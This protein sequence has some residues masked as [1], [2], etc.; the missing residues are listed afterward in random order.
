[1]HHSFTRGSDKMRDFPLQTALAILAFGLLLGAAGMVVP[2]MR[3]PELS[4]FAGIIP[5]PSVPAPPARVTRSETAPAPGSAPKPKEPPVL[6]DDSRGSLDRFYQALLR[7]ERREPGAITRIVHYG[8]SPT[9]ADLI[10]G[11]VRSLLQKQFGNAGHGFILAD[12]PWSWYRHAGM[13]IYAHGWAMLPASRFDADDG[14]FGLGGVTFSGSPPARTA[15]VFERGGASRFEICFLQQPDGGQFTVSAGGQALGTTDTS[16]DL[17]SAFA[18]FEVE[19]AAAE[20][21]VQVTQGKVRWFGVI[22]E[23]PG[24]GVVYDSLGL[25]GGSITVLARMFNQSHWSEQLRHRRPD[26]VIINYG[27]NEAGF[28]DFIEHGYEDE[29]HEVIRRIRRA[30]GN[31]PVLIMSPM[32]RGQRTASGEIETMPTI[33][34]LVDIQRRAA[35]DTGCAF[36]DTFDAMGGEG[37]IARWYGADPRLVAADLIHPFGEG[38]RIVASLFT[39]EIIAGLKRFKLRQNETDH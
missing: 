2:G 34:K 35:R 39:K 31:T 21:D 20:V 36:F 19:P 33:P 10:T 13:K 17:K 29:L 24:P 22:A 32:D 27:T 26:L 6:F 16:G 3:G 5:M 23:G 28:A 38:G 12:N 25:N 8:D 15:I 37:T 30:L 14:M 9:T 11:D 1:M 7:C 18:A 4:Q